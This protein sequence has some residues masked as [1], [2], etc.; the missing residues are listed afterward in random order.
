MIIKFSLIYDYEKYCLV[1]LSFF[2]SSKIIRKLS[3]VGQ[4]NKVMVQFL[5]M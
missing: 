4:K 1:R 2:F 3:Q 5:T